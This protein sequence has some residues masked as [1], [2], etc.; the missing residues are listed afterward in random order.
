MH[1]LAILWELLAFESLTSFIFLASQKSYQIVVSCLSIS[2]LLKM[3]DISNWISSGN[4]Y[5]LFRQS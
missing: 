3:E 1:C 2:V 4:P 5:E